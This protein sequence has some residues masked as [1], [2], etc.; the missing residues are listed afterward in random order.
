MTENQISKRLCV[1]TI[2]RMNIFQHALIL[3]IRVY[4]AVVSPIILAILG[5]S[6][7][8]GFTPSCSQYAREAVARHGTIIGGWLALRR[9]VRCHP[10]G[11]CGADP[12]PAEAP[13][14]KWPLLKPRKPGICHGS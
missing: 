4:Q 14:W 8:C 12:P 3:A 11:D 1:N 13:K 6:A 2:Q 7:R 10:W 5:P 9:L